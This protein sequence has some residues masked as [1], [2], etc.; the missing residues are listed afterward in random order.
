MYNTGLLIFTVATVT[1]AH[2][3]IACQK[4]AEVLDA[5][6]ITIAIGITF[7]ISQINEYYEITYNLNDSIFSSSFYMLTGLH[8]LHVLAGVFFLYICT[9]R[10]CSQDF[11]CLHYVG[12]MCGI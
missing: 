9:E 6:Y 3:C 11:T 10:I 7:L 12:L 4:H 1:Y 5:L 8:G 2:K